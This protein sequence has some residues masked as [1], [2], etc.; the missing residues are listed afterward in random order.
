MR[1]YTTLQAVYLFPQILKTDFQR[2]RR[3]PVF[4][5][6]WHRPQTPFRRISFCG[7]APFRCFSLPPPAEIFWKTTRLAYQHNRKLSRKW[8]RHLFK[9]PSGSQSRSQ[10]ET[11]FK[12]L[13]MLPNNQNP[14]F[15]ASP[16]TV[17]LSVC[18]YKRPACPVARACTV[19][20][21]STKFLQRH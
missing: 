18:I 21:P 8:K 6:W 13:G 1:R 15:S 7:C 19:R 5:C 11:L 12:G 17:G 16:G 4:A 20:Q 3:K 2:D 14:Q 10:R 9:N